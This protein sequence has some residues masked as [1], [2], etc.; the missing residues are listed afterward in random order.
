MAIRMAIAK[1]L[2]PFLLTLHA[3]LLLWAVTG[4]VEWFS[5]S[6]PWPPIS[7][8]LFPRWLL[9]LHWLSVIFASLI[10]LL[11]FTLKWKWTPKAIVPAYAFMAL[12]CAIETIGFLTHP[13]R[14]LAMGLEYAAYIA[15]PMALH[16][17][18]T[19]KSRFESQSECYK[20]QSVDRTPP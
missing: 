18:P 7:N 3:L 19:L 6:T 5:P 14:F 10:F 16:F 15:I 20:P 2:P 4:L 9:F 13:L 1:I 17:V 8:P 12:V 11:G